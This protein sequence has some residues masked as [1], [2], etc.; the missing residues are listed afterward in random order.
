MAV[1]FHDSSAAAP[2]ESQFANF[3]E[4]GRRLERLVGEIQGARREAGGGG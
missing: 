1:V 2:A 3:V 4:Y